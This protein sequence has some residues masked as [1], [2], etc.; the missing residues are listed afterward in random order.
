M[1]GILS[2]IESIVL[3]VFSV[4]LLIEPGE[5]HAMTH[6]YLLSDQNKKL[7]E[8][9]E[10]LRDVENKI[11]SHFIRKKEMLDRIRDNKNDTNKL[12]EKELIPQTQNNDD[13]NTFG[14][15]NNDILIANDN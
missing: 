1:V 9:I 8:K 12:L 14:N 6:I 11:N 7:V 10:M 3:A 5:H 2:I 4:L 13:L 15:N